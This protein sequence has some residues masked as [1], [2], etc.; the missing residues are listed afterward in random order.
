[1][2]K[3]ILKG[4][5]CGFTW[6]ASHLLPG[7]FKCSRMHGHNYVMDIEISSDSLV[8]GMVID[9]VEIKKDVRKMIEIY[10]HRLMLPKEALIPHRTSMNVKG[11]GITTEDSTGIDGIYQ[12]SYTGMNNN[13]KLYT[14]PQEDV[15]FLPY[16]NVVTAENLAKYFAFEI[17]EIVNQ[18]IEENSSSWNIIEVTIFEDSGQGAIYQ[19]SNNKE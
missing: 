7:H 14:I 8:N 11:I 9:F 19:I 12:I 13:A 15:V 2:V 4:E 5:D 16:L 3:I 18:I 17:K 6:S 1:M 10:D